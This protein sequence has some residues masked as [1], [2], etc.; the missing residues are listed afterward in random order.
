M[1]RSIIVC[2][3]AHRVHLT[4]VAGVGCKYMV[5]YDLVKPKILR[6]VENMGF[7]IP[8]ILWRYMLRRITRFYLKKLDK[9]FDII[10]CEGGT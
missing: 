7:R 4:W 9:R 1:T 3:G 6:R 10:F 2:D 8:A 5:F